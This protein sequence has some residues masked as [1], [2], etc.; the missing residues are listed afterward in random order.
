MLAAQARLASFHRALFAVV[1]QRFEPVAE[2]FGP[3]DE[4]AARGYSIAEVRFTEGLATQ[5]ELS[6]ARVDLGVARANQVQ[7]ARDV[8]LARLKLALLRDLPLGVSAN[9]APGF[10]AGQR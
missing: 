9:T 3:L 5:V 6:Q 8:A 1:P 10:G 4:Q 2:G 7:A